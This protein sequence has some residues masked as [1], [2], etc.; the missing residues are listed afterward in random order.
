[1]TLV[2]A[3]VDI[4]PGLILAQSRI[5]VVGLIFEK[6]LQDFGQLFLDVLEWSVFCSDGESFDGGADI[7]NDVWPKHLIGGGGCPECRVGSQSS[8]MGETA[9]TKKA[10]HV[11]LVSS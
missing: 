1:M 5:E 4:W 8:T 6:I 2:K 9:A 7:S 11:W 10:R 3:L